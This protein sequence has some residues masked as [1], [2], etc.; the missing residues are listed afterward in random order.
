VIASQ[1]LSNKEDDAD[2]EELDFPSNTNMP[3]S[4]EQQTSRQDAPLNGHTGDE[5]VR[6]K[7]SSNS[8][9]KAKFVNAYRYYYFSY[10]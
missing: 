3:T 9:A 5:N 4:P 10:L 6:I 1:R 2:S 7:E 8:L